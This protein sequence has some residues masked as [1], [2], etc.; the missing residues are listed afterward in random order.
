MPRMAL[1][2]SLAIVACVATFPV[3]SYG[4]TARWPSSTVTYR[5]H[6]SYG[7]AVKTAVKRWNDAPTRIRLVKAAKGSSANIN[8]YRVWSDEAFA[9]RASL[10]PGGA[11]QINA[12][13]IGGPDRSTV[14]A[15][16]F[17]HELGHAIGLMHSGQRCSI[18]YL[19]LGLWSRCGYEE[20]AT[21][22]RCGPQRA[23]ANAVNRLYDWPLFRGRWAPTCPREWLVRP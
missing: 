17:A 22:L 12:K 3:L 23:D 2:T 6:T 7:Y 18:M 1:L 21:R 10:P 8:V 20:E 15:D 19:Q 11:V 16:V 9:G 5:N 14:Q 13:A 4:H